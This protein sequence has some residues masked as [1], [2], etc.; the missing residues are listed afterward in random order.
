MTL[1]ELFT[2]IG[3]LSKIL[4]KYGLSC[5]ID[6]AFTIKGVGEYV[7]DVNGVPLVEYFKGNYPM[8]N[9]FYAE[10]VK[11]LQCSIEAVKDLCTH[12]GL[13]NL[14]EVWTNWKGPQVVASNGMY[15]TGR[16]TYARYRCGEGTDDEFFIDIVANLYI[17]PM[18]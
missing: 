17:V 4:N 2:D 1:R 3:A 16:M 11:G 7:Y 12:N 8:T 5:R 13:W 14:T 6:L 15:D 9:N 10:V 18:E